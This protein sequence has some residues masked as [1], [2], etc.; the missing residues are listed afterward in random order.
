VVHQLV[1]EGASTGVLETVLASANTA[2]ANPAGPSAG[3]WFEAQRSVLSGPSKTV[4]TL[5]TEMLAT[6]TFANKQKKREEPR[7]LA[8]VQRFVVDAQEDTGL[9][10][11]AAVRSPWL[12]GVVGV[13]AVCALAAVVGGVAYAVVRRR[14]GS[15]SNAA[16]YGRVLADEESVSVEM[17]DM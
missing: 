8:L 11:V 1:S 14:R 16:A 2:F 3:Y 12:Y 7:R 13:A 5:H 4:W 10:H 9:D 15:S 17:Q 6:P